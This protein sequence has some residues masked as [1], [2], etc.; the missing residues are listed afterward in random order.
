MEFTEFYRKMSEVLSIWKFVIESKVCHQT[1]QNE[2]LKIITYLYLKD[3]LWVISDKGIVQAVIGAYRINEF[4][5]SKADN[6]PEKDEGEILFI[7]FACSVGDDIFV[8]RK[9]L[10][11]YLKT[12]EIK[13]LI[14]CDYAK[15]GYGN[16][17]RFNLKGALHESTKA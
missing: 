4:D 7:P 6:L 11:E 8:W 17:R 12:N 14:F 3:W 13:E 1:S 15:D 5:E 10:R 2:W 9:L 16:Y